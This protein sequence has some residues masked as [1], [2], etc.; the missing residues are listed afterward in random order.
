MARNSTMERR[1]RPTPEWPPPIIKQIA[2]L[3]LFASVLA[4]NAAEPA[5]IL[6]DPVFFTGSIL[7]MLAA[8]ALAVALTIRPRTVR[9]EQLVPGLDVIAIA[10]LLVDNPLGTTVYS[11]LLLLPVFWLASEAGRRYVLYSF[12][13]V[14][15]VTFMPL[16]A[17]RPVVTDLA[18]L[19]RLVFAWILITL[20]AYTVNELARRSRAT[21]DALRSSA[22]RTVLALDESKKNARQLA[23]SQAELTQAVERFRQVW[24]AVTE[25]SVIG[26]DAAGLIDAWNPGAERMLGLTEADVQGRANIVEFHASDVVFDTLVAE[27]DGAA[28]ERT[29]VAHDGS[30]VPVE[31]TVTRRSDSGGAAAGYLFVARDVSRE[32]EVTR[33]KD[34]FIGL[35]SHELRTP[36]SSILGYL[37]LLRD[38]NEDPEAVDDRAQYIEVIERN[39]NRLLRLVGDLLLTAQ[40]ESGMSY[41][42]LE[43]QR[44]A[45]VVEGS[46]L[47]LR[48]RIDAAGLTLVPNIDREVVVPGDALRLG[49]AVDNLLSNAIKF[50]PR[51]GTLTMT[52]AR[53]G[54]TARLSVADTGI[55]IPAGEVSQLFGRFFR[56]STATKSAISGIGLGLTIT[57]AIVEAHHGTIDLES[58]EGVGTTFIIT[59][60]LVTE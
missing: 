33:L 2:G 23:E 5:G 7:C 37:E 51:G 6:R 18:S 17:G 57:K 55:G 46:I 28:H 39:S 8:T 22:A 38:D 56:A 31:V 25:Q 47:S 10:M 44:L 45:Q 35:V 58:E 16:L 34:E 43:P 14:L 36:L 48:P 59:L 1:A 50:T 9:H 60:P 29:Y 41:L 21:A 53:D 20:S 13:A 24:E 4:I 49:Q 27:D 40:V 19:P 15:V 26:T 52:V 32:R 12:L 30:E 54:N 3:V 11:L 42:A